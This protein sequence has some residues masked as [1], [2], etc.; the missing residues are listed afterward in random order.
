MRLV[1][2][3]AVPLE[4]MGANL[5]RRCGGRG[6]WFIGFQKTYGIGDLMLHKL[7]KVGEVVTFRLHGVAKKFARIE[8]LISVIET[9]RYGATLRDAKLASTLQVLASAISA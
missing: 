1:N 4:R 9:T 5:F 6:A 2:A 3:N 7:H 8:G